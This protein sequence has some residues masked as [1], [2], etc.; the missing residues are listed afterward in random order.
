MQSI[1]S[2]KSGGILSRPSF[3]LAWAL[4]LLALFIAALLVSSVLPGMIRVHERT[5]NST[6]TINTSP[7]DPAAIEE[8]IRESKNETHRPLPNPLQISALLNTPAMLVEIAID[9]PTTWPDS[10]YPKLPFPFGDLW[11]W[12]AVSWP[13]YALPLWWLAGRG[14]DGLSQPDTFPISPRIRLGEAIFMGIL[15]ALSGAVGIGLFFTAESDSPNDPLKWIVV[16]CLLWF[17]FGL[18]S[19]IAWV[20]QRRLRMRLSQP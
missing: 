9:L 11:F 8:M 10:W 15:G 2:S 17:S 19:G 14:V 13:I 18:I 6:T 1:A 16:S 20:R 4:P 7:I 3:R 5:A 12:R